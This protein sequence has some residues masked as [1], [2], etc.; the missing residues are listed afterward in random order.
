MWPRALRY[1]PACIAG[2]AIVIAT[3][4]CATRTHI[5]YDGR[6]QHVPST[7]TTDPH[8]VYQTEPVNALEKVIDESSRYEI[9]RLSFPSIG[10]NGQT[11]NLVTVDYHRSRLPGAH[12]VVIVLPIWGRQVYPSNA[13]IRTLRKRSNG[14][15][16]IFNVLGESFLID[17]PRLGVETDEEQFME[18]WADGAQQEIT[19]L[20]D[21]RRL[22]DWAEARPEIDNDHIG[23]IGFSHGAMFAPTLT[24]QEPRISATALVMGGAHPQ[25]VIA[26]CI[27]AR[28]EGIQIWAETTFGW[29][30]EEMEM[31]LEPLYGP[32]D[33]ARYP[34]RVDPAQV[35]MIEAGKD[36][37]IPKSC[38][39]DLWEVMGQPERY[40][41]NANHRHSFYTMTPLNLNWA[42]KRIWEFFGSRLLS[43]TKE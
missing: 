34:D 21:M 17:W 2:L 19:T 6:A 26:Q 1:R 25:R 5:T 15:L 20:V 40:I 28:T 9:R 13:I 43:P 16:H 3:T 37:C 12:P 14:A 22:I 29:S 4:S 32:M 8:F 41:I 27:G 24:T 42:R 23:L 7:E 11:D 36:E 10:S 30:R 35:L 33:P 18:L 31:L 38:R 39:D